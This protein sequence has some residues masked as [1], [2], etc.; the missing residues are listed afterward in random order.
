MTSEENFNSHWL[1]Y[2]KSRHLCELPPETIARL[3]YDLAWRDARIEMKRQC[4][5]LMK[6]FCS[7]EQFPDDFDWLQMLLGHA[8]LRGEI[9]LKAGEDDE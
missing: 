8:Y 9:G 4:L 3:Y 7:G 6:G 1:E 2:E 5:E